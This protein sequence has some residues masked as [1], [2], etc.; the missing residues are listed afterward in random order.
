MN[1]IDHIFGFISVYFN[2]SYSQRVKMTNKLLFY[3]D[4]KVFFLPHMWNYIETIKCPIDI[5][6][7]HGHG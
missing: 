2:T 7:V 5:N 1:E 4:P 3:P 6:Y